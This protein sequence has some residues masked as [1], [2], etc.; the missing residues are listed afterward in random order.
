MD[1]LVGAMRPSSIRITRSSARRLLHVVRDQQRE[2]CRCPGLDQPCISMRV[3]ASIS[4]IGSREQQPRCAQRR[5]TPRVALAPDR[6]A[7]SFSAVGQADRASTRGRA[8]AVVGRPRDGQPRARARLPPDRSGVVVHPSCAAVGG[9]VPSVADSSPATASSALSAPR[10]PRCDE[11]AGLYAH[12]VCAHVACAVRLCTPRTSSLHA[13]RSGCDAP[14]PGR[15]EGAVGENR[16]M[17]HGVC[18]R[19][20]D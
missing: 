13:A 3:S 7:P 16:A 15:A 10:A 11:L 8:R 2:R 18:L 20:P 6:R 4:P 5:D 9:S 19:S 14:L 12:C 17:I 1:V